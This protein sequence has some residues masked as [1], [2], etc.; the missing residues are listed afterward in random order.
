MK[1][2]FHHRDTENTE[3]EFHHKGTKDTKLRQLQKMIL[4][5]CSRDRCAVPSE[6][7]FPSELRA[8][9]AFVVKFFLCVLCVSVVKSAFLFA[10]RAG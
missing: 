5:H 9:C 3:E 8:L 7:N 1:S 10:Q 4:F 2:E 6:K